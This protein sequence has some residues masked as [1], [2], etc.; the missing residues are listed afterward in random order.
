MLVR[1][2]AKHGGGLSPVI[3]GE[4]QAPKSHHNHGNHNLHT[5]PMIRWICSVATYIL[6]LQGLVEKL[7]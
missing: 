4:D 2:K 6:V 3:A 1:V 7:S 5:K